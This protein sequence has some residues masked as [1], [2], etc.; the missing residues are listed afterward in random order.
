MRK[1]D[2]LELKNVLKKIIAPSL[3]YVVAMLMVKKYYFKF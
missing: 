2:I 1:K 3:K